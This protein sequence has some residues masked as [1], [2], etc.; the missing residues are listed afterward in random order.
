MRT[1]SK[2][3]LLLQAKITADGE[4]YRVMCSIEG[5]EWFQFGRKTKN[6][7]EALWIMNR[8]QIDNPK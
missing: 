8:F 7:M 4:Y 6:V 3:G 1:T 5:G 2:D